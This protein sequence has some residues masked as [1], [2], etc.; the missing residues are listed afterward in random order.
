VGKECQKI[1]PDG[2]SLTDVLATEAT[3]PI[4]APYIASYPNKTL[5][6]PAIMPYAQKDVPA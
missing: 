1:V 2:L 3:I 4:A 6:E 5:T